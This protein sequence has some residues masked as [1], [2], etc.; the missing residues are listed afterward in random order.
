MNF[1][2]LSDWIIVDGYC[3]T[4]IIKDGNVD[5]IQDRVA[6]IEKTPRVRVDKYKYAVENKDGIG[7]VCTQRDAWIC[8]VKRDNGLNK[9]SRE[10]CDTMLQLLGWE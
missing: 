3:A 2:E 7:A 4:K 1:K 6:F 10:W 5:N 9:E 8:G